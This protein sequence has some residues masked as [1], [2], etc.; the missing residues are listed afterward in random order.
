MRLELVKDASNA[1]G[2]KFDL[3]KWGANLAGKP[4]LDCGTHAC[5]VGVGLLSGVFEKEG[6]VPRFGG[7]L[8]MP[9]F[10]NRTDWSAVRAFFGLTQ[11]EAVYLFSANSY[12]AQEGSMAEQMVIDRLSSF[13]RNEVEA[14][15]YGY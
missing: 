10:E 6:F 14:E 12:I 11:N 7:H 13:A 2:T 15:M 3:R 8:I 5:A 4:A 9:T 1:Q